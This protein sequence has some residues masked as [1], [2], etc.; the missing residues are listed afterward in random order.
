MQAGID[1]QQS[2]L[3]LRIYRTALLS[4]I[5]DERLWILSRQDRV[6]FVITPRGHEVAQAA[7]A[8]AMRRGLD[9]AWPY[10]RDLAVGFALGVTPYEIFLGAL[11]R[12]L[13]PHSGGRQ[14]TAHMSSRQLNI[15][16]VSSAIASQVPHAVGA[17]YAALVREV[18]SVAFCWMGEGATSAGQTHE[19]MNL[20][21]IRR[22]PVLFL[23]ENNGLAI[24][25]PQTLQM[26]IQS[27]AARGAAYNMPAAS[28]D[29]SDALAV[30]NT[31]IE[32]RER[33]RRGAGPSLIELRVVRISPHS[34]QDD[35][36]Y[37]TDSERLAAS[38]QDPIV[39]L[40][41]ALVAAGLM[42]RD[43]DASLTSHLTRIV[44]IDEDRAL[45]QPD[46]MPSRARRWLFVGEQPLDEGARNDSAVTGM[47]VFDD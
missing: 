30:Y 18:D 39:A 16:S 40:R 3:L 6:S 27:V 1:S 44:R 20:A 28:I 38:A 7:S 31:V 26:P 43:E 5:V 36:S 4:R 14:L 22:L 9:S 8:A 47:S 19:A 2:R 17:G 24:S 46:P 21:A 15:G 11:G 42:T 32:A 35:D 34:S 12:G 10:Y 23:V 13:D 33:A 41:T 25:V 29:G 37:R 45:M